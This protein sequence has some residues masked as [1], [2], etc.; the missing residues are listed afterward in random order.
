MEYKEELENM[1]Q[2]ALDDDEEEYEEDSEL[3]PNLCT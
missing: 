1:E 2:D 3:D